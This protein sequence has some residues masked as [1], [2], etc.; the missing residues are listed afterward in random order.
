MMI[1]SLPMTMTV[2]IPTKNNDAQKCTNILSMGNYATK[3]LK[4]DFTFRKTN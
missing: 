1:K 3:I 2:M 4:F